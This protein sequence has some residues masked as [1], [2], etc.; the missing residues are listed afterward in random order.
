M[1]DHG[2]AGSGIVYTSSVKIINKDWN[3]QRNDWDYSYPN[4]NDIFEEYGLAALT[5]AIG[6]LLAAD[7]VI[8]VGINRENTPTDYSAFGEY[9]FTAIRNRFCEGHVLFGD[10]TMVG[11]LEHDA[12][13][14]FRSAK[15]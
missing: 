3:E 10:V 12:Y 5:D 4:V 6:G 8:F 7:G 1:S 9:H 14:Y 13:P 11:S 15:D 2:V